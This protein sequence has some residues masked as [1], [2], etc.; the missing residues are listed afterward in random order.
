MASADSVA[1]TPTSSINPFNFGRIIRGL[2]G[3][4]HRFADG[5][6]NM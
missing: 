4:N 1:F 3:M 2:C 6:F 5:A